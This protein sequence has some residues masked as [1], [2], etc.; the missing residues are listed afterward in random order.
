MVKSMTKNQQEV[1]VPVGA[2]GTQRAQAQPRLF[3]P[4]GEVRTSRH[5]LMQV[6]EQKHSVLAFLMLVAA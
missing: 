2:S 1:N 5:M 4:A 3:C 6:S